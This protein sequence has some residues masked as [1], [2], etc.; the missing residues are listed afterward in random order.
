MMG[1][2]TYIFLIYDKI[3]PSLSGKKLFLFGVFIILLIAIPLTAY[4][5]QKQQETRSRAT[6]STT[7]S[8]VPTSSESSPIAK[9]VG[10]TFSLD[11]MIDP[12]TNEVIHTTLS[13]N[14]DA[15]KISTSD[16]GLSPTSALPSVLEG[17]IYTSGNATVVVS[18]GTDITKSIKTPTKIATLTF[19][20]LTPT[21][22]TPTQI[23]FG[24]QT[25]V[26]ATIADPETNVL[27]NIIPAFISIGGAAQVNPTATPTVPAPTSP[28]TSATPNQPPLCTAINVDRATE[29]EAPLSITFT[30][31]GSDTDGTVNKVTFNFGD[32]P[33]QDVTSAGGIGTNSVSVQLAHT[34]NNPGTYTANVILTDNS[35][36]TSTPTSC[37]QTITVVLAASPTDGA[38]QQNPPTETPVPADRATMTPAGP[39]DRIIG[40]G[41]IGAIISIIGAIVFF[42]L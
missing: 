10:D 35:G 18:T 19:K 14:Y 7:L 28:Q 16:A 29:G 4:L 40:V 20:A 5:V 27:S 21:S 9:S 30:A 15:T 13:I 37:T 2:D 36:G 34:Y 22:G 33:T 39:G 8:F 31:N 17:P 26:T 23:T 1:L 11:V 32:G 41:A 24:N 3:M 25:T 38:A 6:K 42:A 12:G